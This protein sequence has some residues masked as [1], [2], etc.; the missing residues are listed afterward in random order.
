MKRGSW[1]WEISLGRLSPK[2]FSFHPK[3]NC[4]HGFANPKPLVY[5]A[6]QLAAVKKPQWL[7]TLLN[8]VDPNG[9]THLN[10]G[11]TKF[12]PSQ[13]SREEIVLRK[14]D[15][16]SSAVLDDLSVG[17]ATDRRRSRPWK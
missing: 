4:L 16:G 13:F 14:L 15:A 1:L 3:K 12:S 11:A 2:K 9:S 10:F 6:E 7:R 17:R 8:R 5:N